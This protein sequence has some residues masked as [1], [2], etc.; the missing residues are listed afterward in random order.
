[1]SEWRMIDTGDRL[2]NGNVKYLLERD[3]KCVSIGNANVC[4]NALLQNIAPGDTYAE[5][6]KHGVC[7]AMMSYEYVM[8]EE[9]LNQAFYNGDDEE[10]D[11][12]ERYIGW[13]NGWLN[14]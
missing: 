7:T 4:N 1:M 11:K 13:L 2:D 9:L 6:N 8:A 5:Y 3:Q 10:Y 14:G 12:T